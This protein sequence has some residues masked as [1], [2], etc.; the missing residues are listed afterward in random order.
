MLR[1]LSLRAPFRSL[2]ESSLEGVTFGKRTIVYGHNGS[3]K[4]TFAQLLHS[5]ANGAPEVEVD[6]EP[7]T[8]ASQRLGTSASPDGV[9]VS[10]FGKTWVKANLDSF[11]DGSSASAIVT[12][13]A[14]AVTAKDDE[15]DALARASS[16]AAN[17]ETHRGASA[18]AKAGIQAVVEGLQSAIESTLKPHDYQ[19][20][21]RN[22]Y[23]VPKV[24]AL[25]AEVPEDFSKN[26]VHQQNLAAL[27]QPAP[28]P[29]RHFPAPL[30]PG[31]QIQ[32]SV[33]ALLLRDSHGELI[34]DLLGSGEI[35]RWVQAGLAIHEHRTEC[36]YCGG[37]LSEDRVSKLRRHFDQS[38]ADI[39]RSAEA[40]IANSIR[41]KA[42]LDAWAAE[43]PEQSRVD[44]TLLQA[45]SDAQTEL[46]LIVSSTSDFLDEARRMA[47]AKFDE[48]ERTDHPAFAA[49]V[50]SLSSAKWEQLV[51]EQNALSSNA[52]A[53]KHA[54]HAQILDD[55]VGTQASTFKAFEADEAAAATEIDRLEG[56]LS[57]AQQEL[58]RLRALHFTSAKMADQI[59][60]DLAH[61]YGKGHLS[62]EVIEDGF[63][64]RCIRDGEP[65]NHLSEG[66]RH[67]LALLYFLR[68]LE[69]AAVPVAPAQRLVVI[70]DPSSSL[71]REAIFATHSWLLDMLGGYGQSMIFTHDFELMRLL[72][73]SQKSQ[74]NNSHSTI[75]KGRKQGAAPNEVAAADQEE[76]FPRIQFL[77]IHARQSSALARVSAVRPIPRTIVNSASEYHYLFDQVVGGVED[78]VSA[79]SLF[80]LPNAA[81]RLLESFVSFKAP[82]LSNFEAQL[83]KLAI[84]ERSASYRDVYDFCNR[85]SH[86]EGREV[87]MPLDVSSVERQLARCLEFLRDVDPDH[88]ALMLKATGRS[89]SPLSPLP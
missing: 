51:A 52:V 43:F 64:Y 31:R 46:D 63:S 85:H 14:P 81:R 48:P 54:L 88:F 84:D 24:K 62:I 61:V 16:I 28:E 55:L 66:E 22:R 49:P 76:R 40:E 78:P 4:S 71:D 23:N 20:F 73:T 44:S 7:S 42:E 75:S 87:V 21:T 36:A 41:L 25:L 11:L 47:Q 27:G 60:S 79:P 38:R 34:D 9:H 2:D 83:R 82:E 5:I 89:Q 15:R 77:E 57:E 37:G 80:L 26:P 19:H 69:D 12:L 1:S 13:G 29:L 30:M 56:L 72:M 68:H 18:A 65:A 17:I 10:V 53:S 45:W 74:L 59:S 8:G 50:P 86:G 35:L 67:T 33:N 6:W 70:D 39:Q 32:E 58:E 3:G